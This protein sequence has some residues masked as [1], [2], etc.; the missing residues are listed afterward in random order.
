M[1]VSKPP[2]HHR[3]AILLL[4][5][6]HNVV[7]FDDSDA[8]GRVALFL[9][10]SMVLLSLDNV[11]SQHLRILYLDLGVVENVVVVIDVLYYFDGARVLPL[12]LR[13]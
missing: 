9:M 2:T 5:V 4:L 1:L 12:F 10:P 6:H 13:F 8:L 7:L 3:L 11:A